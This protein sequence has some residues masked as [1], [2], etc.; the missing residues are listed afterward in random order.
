MLTNFNITLNWGK[1]VV[2][3]WRKS[4]L[5]LGTMLIASMLLGQNAY[6]EMDGPAASEAKAPQTREEIPAL[7]T[8]NSKTF[9]TDRPDV[10]VQRVSNGP[11]HYESENGQFY[12]IATDL[13][14][15]NAADAVKDKEVSRNSAQRLKDLKKNI[16]AKKKNG[17][18]LSQETDGA[19]YAFHVPY[20]AALPKNIAAGYSIGNGADEL[21][22]IPQ[23]AKPSKGQ[24]DAAKPGTMLYENVWEATNVRLSITAAG[25]KEDIVLL[26]AKAPDSFTFEVKGELDKELRSGELT[27]VP[28]WLEDSAGQ[29]RDVKTT[30]RTAGNKT[31][32]DL[33]WDDAGLTYPVTIDPS[34]NSQ[35]SRVYN[36][37]S[38]NP[39]TL[40]QG[41]LVGSEQYKACMS[42]VQF[43]NFQIPKAAQVTNVDLMVYGYNNLGTSMSVTVRPLLAP[44]TMQLNYNNPPVALNVPG[45]TA[46]VP[47]SSKYD[48][49]R[50]RDLGIDNGYFR[51]GFVQLGMYYAG[52]SY[53]MLQ[54][55]S[56]GYGGTTQL[57]IT[58]I[59]GRNN[60]VYD[61]NGR[62][63]F[64]RT[65]TG[66]IVN[67]TV[68][69][70]NGNTLTRKSPY[71]TLLENYDFREGSAKWLIGPDMSITKEMSGD[72]NG[73]LKFSS[74]TPTTSKSV[75][76]AYAVSAD[77]GRSFTLTADLLDNTT[78]G[79]V[80]VTWKEYN[81]YYGEV[82]SGSQLLTTVRGQWSRKTIS[83][84]T[85]TMTSWITVQIVAD[86]G[87]KGTAY[88]DFVSLMPGI[89]NAGFNNGLSGWRGLDSITTDYANVKEGT[90]S[91]KF[92]SGSLGGNISANDRIP[93]NGRAQ[94]NISAWFYNN[95]TNSAG[96]I[97]ILL[98]EFGEDGPPLAY[99]FLEATEQ[100]GSGAWFNKS[101][102]FT[103][104]PN[105]RYMSIQVMFNDSPG[106]A[107]V[108]GLSLT[109]K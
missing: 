82:G 59:D 98:M 46:D 20:R 68:Y 60:Y 34:V 88:V 1:V 31:Y 21:T 77:S 50:W 29:R 92:A 16:A 9:E 89:V 72:G 94:Y 84:A 56:S 78:S 41:L 2:K 79:K 14:D 45:V 23:N 81:Y 15:E 54:E 104:R 80:Y 106:T 8:E 40:N 48:A 86:A 70:K 32:L 99:N 69:D 33:T 101:L 35:R 3:R 37:C 76:Q 22:F 103:T 7:R 85:T 63:S 83:F 97:T 39:D 13:T 12:E 87:T 108:D 74:A 109:L 93:A 5:A 96:K 57:E 44:I 91:L 6:G 100:R 58:Y 38:N 105:T 95:F 73:S 65:K 52:G 61:S 36:T 71:Y 26:N 11:L 107:Y 53:G 43:S 75:T 10:Y 24:K 67:D 51:T 90:A 64:I 62:L 25:V 4:R 19:Y 17:K 49:Y 27:I 47:Y 42:F 28:A 102:D 66:H 30:K 55:G 18:S